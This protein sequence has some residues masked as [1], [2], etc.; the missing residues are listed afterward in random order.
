[1]NVV[2]L[3]KVDSLSHGFKCE[4]GTTIIR[5]VGRNLL[6]RIVY[7]HDGKEHVGGDKRWFFLCIRRGDED[8]NSGEVR[9]SGGIGRGTRLKL[10][11]QGRKVGGTVDGVELGKNIKN[12]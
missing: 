6:H 3:S 9:P 10:L 7:G 1:M 11:L 4:D 2:Y 8:V 5:N 12:P